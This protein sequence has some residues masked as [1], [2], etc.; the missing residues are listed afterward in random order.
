MAL[1][2]LTEI[3]AELNVAPSTL[4]YQAKQYEDLLPRRE[5][6]GER[7]PKYEA[8][9]LDILRLIMDKS[10]EGL[11]R[12]EIKDLI[13]TQYETVYHEGNQIVLSNDTDV[14]S[15]QTLQVVQELHDLNTTLMQVIRQQRETLQNKDEEIDRLT[16]ELWM[17]I[18]QRN[19]NRKILDMSSDTSIFFG[20]I[21]RFYETILFW[22]RPK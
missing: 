19:Y 2:S 10:S 1:Y 9:A 22:M 5:V 13:Y 21:R 15:N 6:E 16:H 17:T 8:E 7:W 12:E 3:A 18:G 11:S 20:N 14:T 4:R